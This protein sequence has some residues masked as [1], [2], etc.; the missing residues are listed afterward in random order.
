MLAIHAKVMWQEASGWDSVLPRT[1]LYRD[2]HLRLTELDKVLVSR[3]WLQ[4]SDVQVGF[5]QLVAPAAPTA[6]VRGAVPWTRRCHLLRQWHM[7]LQ[8]DTEVRKTVHLP[9]GN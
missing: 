1:P 6:A 2:R 3:A 8:G 4:S 7:Q 9:V 5:A